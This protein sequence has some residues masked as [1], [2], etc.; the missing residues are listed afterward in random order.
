MIAM[1]TPGFLEIGQYSCFSEA[2]KDQMTWQLY[3]GKHTS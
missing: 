3:Q 1:P 2:I